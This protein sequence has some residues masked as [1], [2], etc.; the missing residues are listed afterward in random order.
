MNQYTPLIIEIAVL[1]LLWLAASGMTAPLRRRLGK[2]GSGRAPASTLALDL[3]A[4]LSRPLL[5]LGLTQLAVLL[6]ANW[7]AGDVWL[8]AHHAHLTAWQIFWLGLGAIALVEGIAHTAYHWRGETFPIPDLLL[9]IIRAVLV[10]AVGFMVLRMELGIDIGP[11]L[12]STALLTAV[13][14]FALQGVLGNLLAGMSLHLVRTLRPGIWV[15]VDGVEGRIVKTNWRETRIRTRGGHMYIIPNAR[16]AESKIHNYSEPTP[17]RRHVVSVGASYSDAPDEVLGA[18][19]SAARAVPEVRRN[20]APEA[21]ITAFQDYGINYR[22]EFWTTELQRHNPIDGAVN[23]NIW[24]Q[25]KRKGIEIPFPMSDKLLN[26]FMAVVYKQRKLPPVEEDVEAA[27]GDLR[28]SDLC[29]KVFVDTDG[30]PLLSHDDLEIVAPLV[31]RQPYTHGETLCA[32]GDAGETFWVIASGK[33]LGRVEQ[34]SRVAAEFELRPGAVVGEMSALT[35]VPRSATLTVA[36]SSELLE[37]GHEAFRALLSL[38]E[39]IPER[40]SEL[41]AR[42]AAENRAALEVLARQR[43]DGEEVQLEQK[44]ILK[45][46]LRMIGR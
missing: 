1:T 16:I 23:R 9:D 10:L 43:E 30:N 35:G 14:G 45:R 33:L 24:Y 6:S 38:H 36:E 22:L 28:D 21:M 25:F 39:D 12:A 15:D 5:V 31:K 44:G 11:L 26:D 40:L 27:V 19:L 2:E 46:L 7:P 18:M 34:D 17:L 37:F 29:T 8:S 4:Y 32:Q 42:R 41:A 13:I 20:P 3:F